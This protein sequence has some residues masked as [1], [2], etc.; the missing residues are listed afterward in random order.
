MIKKPELPHGFQ[1]RVLK[2]SIR[3]EGHRVHDQLVDIFLI[4]WW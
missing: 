3:D 4:G 2:G 1:A